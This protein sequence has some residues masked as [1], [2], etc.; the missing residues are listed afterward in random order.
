MTEKQA[1]PPIREERE[2]IDGIEYVV[3]FVP[4]PDY[5]ERLHWIYRRLEEYII[6]HGLYQDEPE[7]AD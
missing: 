1:D 6:E 4:V 7:E 3:E 2:V 5:Y